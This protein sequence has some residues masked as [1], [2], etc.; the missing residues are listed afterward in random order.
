MKC[1]F[2]RIGITFLSMISFSPC[3]ANS[4]KIV[5]GLERAQDFNARTKGDF[6]IQVGSFSHMSN[7]FRSQ[8]LLQSRT[9]RPVKISHKRNLYIVLIGPIHSVFELRKTANDLLHVPT[10]QSLARKNPTK[11]TTYAQSTDKKQGHT[12]S[13][14]SSE[15]VPSAAIISPVTPVSHS[16]ANW[17]MAIGSGA[18]FPLASANMYVKNG[19]FYPPPF[20]TDIYSATQ[21]ASASAL[22]N[23]TVGRRWTRESKWF[24]AYSLG[25]FYQHSFTG[26]AGGTVTQ[27]S[28][29]EFTNYNYHWNPSSDILLASIKLNLYD[30]NQFSPYV[31]AGLGGAFNQSHYNETALPDVTPRISPDFSGSSNQFA[32]N[33]GA[34]LDFRATNHLIINVGYLYQNLGNISGKGKGTW[35]STSLN[36]GSYGLNEV[37]VGGTYLF[38]K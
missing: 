29:P 2:V 25:L 18:E 38:N 14:L 12:R 17:F 36:I 21:N 20:D 11:K 5:Y 27:Y 24:P 19:S 4:E 13:A 22:L 1:F 15:S 32:Y 26:N 9:M 31:T 28:D 37:V 10:K 6:Y 16:N 34:G 33:A 7:A 30:K 23:A 35:S 3:F 8:K